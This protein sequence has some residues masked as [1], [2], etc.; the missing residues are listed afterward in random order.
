MT[1]TI[2]QNDPTF[3]RL[4]EFQPH[5]TV[6]DAG[7]DGQHVPRSEFALPAVGSAGMQSSCGQTTTKSQPSAASPAK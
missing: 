2:D 5:E 1:G 6:N 7:R 3:L 4:R